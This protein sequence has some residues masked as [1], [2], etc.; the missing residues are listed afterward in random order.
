MQSEIITLDSHLRVQVYSLG[1]EEKPTV[2]LLHGLGST[3]YSFDEL[4]RLLSFDFRVI[5]LDLPG[6]GNSSYIHNEQFFSMDSLAN[7]VKDVVEYFNITGFHIVGHSVGGNIGI[8]FAN[9]YGSLIKSLVL[10]D[11]GYLRGS[12]LPDNTLKDEMEMTEQHCKN[13]CFSS[14]EDYE[15]NLKSNGFNN[16][17]I[18]MSKKSMKEECG[19][20]KLKVNAEVA[21]F[22]IKNTFHEPTE[23]ILSGIKIPVLL[24]R[25]TLPEQLNVYRQRETKRLLH[26]LTTRVVDV[27]ES[28]HELYW[29]QPVHVSKMIS[30]LD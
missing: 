20:I 16:E 30:N 14:W 4:A 23:N 28:S 8:Y 19:V 11:G 26:H 18:E 6:H 25:S 27:N 10:L 22:I 15:E 5:S 29:E 1:T 24:M 13:Y 9:K 17:L 7:W 2:I 3:G 21:K 12:S